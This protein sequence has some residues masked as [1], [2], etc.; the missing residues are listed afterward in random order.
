MAH[1]EQLRADLL[2]S[3]SH[4]IRTPL[5]SI[6]GNASNLLSHYGQ[7]EDGARQQIFADIYD[8]AQWLIHLVE[9]LLSISRIEN[10]QM[11]LHRSLDVVSD[12]IDEALRHA[13]RKI[14]EHRIVVKTGDEPLLVRMDAGLITQVLINLIN[15]AIKNTPPGSKIVIESEARDGRALL[16]VSDDGPGIPDEVKPHIFEMFYTGPGK[17][18]DGRRGM[19]LGLALCK[20]ILE[21]HDGTITLVDNE[22]TG[23]RFVCTLPMEEVNI[24]E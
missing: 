19:G 5:T 20:S 11:R 6:S 14:S 4:D 8:D 9:N 21:A 13:D 12:V 15:N 1:N 7:L 18:A 22:P 24:H 3:I 23:C 2:R 10:G 17:V 16:T